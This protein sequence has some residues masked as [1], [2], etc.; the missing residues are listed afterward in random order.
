VKQYKTAIQ[1]LV[2]FGFYGGKPLFVDGKKY[3]ELLKKIGIK[4][5]LIEC[6]EEIFQKHQDSNLLPTKHILKTETIQQRITESGFT[7]IQGG[8]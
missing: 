7:V 4:N 6:W 3:Q 1:L 2:W 8:N 5:Q